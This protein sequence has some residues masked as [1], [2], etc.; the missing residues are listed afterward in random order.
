MNN[1]SVL[2]TLRLDAHLAEVATSP[3]AASHA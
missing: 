3:L 1:P 2:S